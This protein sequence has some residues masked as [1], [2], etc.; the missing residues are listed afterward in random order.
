ML[1]G[2]NAGRH[3]GALIAARL[4]TK[5]AVRV[6]EIPHGSQPDQLGT[7]QIHCLCDPDFF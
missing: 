3:A 5:L 2:D 1:D 6:V 4:V 7:D